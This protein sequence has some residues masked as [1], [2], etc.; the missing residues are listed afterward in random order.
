MM[1]NYQLEKYHKKMWY[2]KIVVLHENILS[3]FPLYV[4]IISADKYNY[5][6][7]SY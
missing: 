2:K 7:R 1:L 6:E 5:L 4:K 3:H